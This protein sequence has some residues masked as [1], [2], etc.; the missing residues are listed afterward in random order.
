MKKKKQKQT[1]QTLQQLV[2]DWDRR[3]KETGFCD[4]EDR[5]T[6][7]LKKSG[8]DVVWKPDMFERANQSQDKGYSSITWK[9]SQ[10]E[11][12]RLAGQALYEKEFKNIRM[13][14]IWQL[15]AE[16]HSYPEISEVL[17]LTH[18]KVRRA[19]ERMAKEFC[20]K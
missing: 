15:H 10:A 8:G 17:N 14:L 6:G 16:G 5:K 12:Y 1:A 4:I 9:E 18:D 7:L 19:V 11:Y 3:L 20:L 13:R 2:K